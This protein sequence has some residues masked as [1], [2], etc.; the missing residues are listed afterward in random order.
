MFVDTV[1]YPDYDAD[2]HECPLCQARLAKKNVYGHIKGCKIRNKHL[3]KNF[4]QCP[5]NPTHLVNSALKLQIHL[6]S[7]PDHEEQLNRHLGPDGSC[8]TGNLQ[9][10]DPYNPPCPGLYMS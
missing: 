8:I 4:Y 9:S 2:Y 1:L 6:S 3:L 10:P 7:C 5:A